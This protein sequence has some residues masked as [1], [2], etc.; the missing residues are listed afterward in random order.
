MPSNSSHGAIP[1]QVARRLLEAILDYVD[2][3]LDECDDGLK[4]EWKDGDRILPRLL[5]ETKRSF[6]E[7]LTGKDQ[8]EGGLTAPQI[9]DALRDMEKFLG[10]FEDHR[11]QKRGSEKW[12]FTLELWS[13]SKT[14]NLRQFDLAWER[15]RANNS[16]N[17]NH[18]TIILERL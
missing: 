18:L 4:Y 8:H 5:V 11:L 7:R 16:K 2:S 10:I 6:L 1:R 9:R 17:G 3:Y 14:E 12:H 15:R 13:K